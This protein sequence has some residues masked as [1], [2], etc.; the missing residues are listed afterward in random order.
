MDIINVR[1]KKKVNRENALFS[2]VLK[3]KLNISERPY[4]YNIKRMKS[5]KSISPR[6]ME[7]K[8]RK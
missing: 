1:Y 2:I 6:L 7:R 4:S 3:K 5:E 8:T